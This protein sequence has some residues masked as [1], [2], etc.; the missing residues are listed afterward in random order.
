[1]RSKEK[2]FKFLDLYQLTNKGDGF[3]NGFWHMDDYHLSPE[4]MKEAWRRYVS[5][6]DMSNMKKVIFEKC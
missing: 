1:M 3:S 4:G 2:G 5:E 6:N